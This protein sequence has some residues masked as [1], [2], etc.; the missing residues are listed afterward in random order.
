MGQLVANGAVM[1]FGDFGAGATVT[2]FRPKRG[3]AIGSWRNLDNSRV[4][5]ANGSAEFATG[6]LEF[7][8]NSGELGDV[9]MGNIVTL[10]FANQITIQLGTSS[11][12]VSVSGYSDQDTADWDISTE[13]DDA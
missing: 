6:E 9:I 13:T 2:R 4:I 1:D 10:W 3:T 7:K 12:L 11:G 8:F 5:A